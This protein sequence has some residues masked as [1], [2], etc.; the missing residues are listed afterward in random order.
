MKQ[1]DINKISTEQIND[2]TTN[3]DQ[4]PIINILELINDEDTNVACAVKA[5]IKNIAAI[6]EKIQKN[7]KTGGRVFYLG[8][9]T[10]GRLG[11]L[12]ASEMLPTFNSHDEIIGIIAGGESAL[13]KP[14]EAAED[15]ENQAELDLKDYNLTPKDTV[16]AIG[17]SGRTPYSIGALKY[18]KSKNAY[19]IGLSMSKCSKFRE[20]ADD[21]IEINSGPEVISGSTRLKAGT[22]TKLVLNM[23]STTLMIKKGKTY[24]NLMID[25]RI[26][27]EKLFYRAVNIVQLITNELDSLKIE[28][29]LKETRDVRLTVVMLLF[30]VDLTQAKIIL[31][32]TSNIKTLIEKK[33]KNV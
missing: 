7:F 27:N 25:V 10:S 14:V 28:K 12:D 20:F 24:G 30:E 18:A 26:S 15:D 5:E 16:I 31:E 22:A 23:I 19:A 29:I 13:R 6:I 21:V 17:A 11:V 32:S 33:I 8:A 9:G 2:K 1:A 3:I 4:M